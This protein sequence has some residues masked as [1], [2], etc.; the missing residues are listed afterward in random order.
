MYV[1]Y[2]FLLNILNKSESMPGSGYFLGL[3]LW[4]NNHE[5]KCQTNNYESQLKKMSLKLKM[6]GPLCNQ[7]V[8]LKTD[9]KTLYYSI[10]KLKYSP[11]FWCKAQQ[12]LK[13]ITHCET[14]AMLHKY[15]GY[16]WSIHRSIFAYFNYFASFWI[17]MRH[18]HRT[19]R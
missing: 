5:S 11:H 10:L 4:K 9:S 2:V 13:E 1:H 6:L 14:T 3:I 18:G 7:T 19:E 12:R 8:N 17:F 16:D 15:T